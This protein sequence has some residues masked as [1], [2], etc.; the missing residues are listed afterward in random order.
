MDQNKLG[1]TNKLLTRL[2]RGYIKKYSIRISIAL[3]AMIIVAATTSMQAYIIKPILDSIFI[4]QNMD[5]ILPVSLALLGIAVLR[6]G[7][8][9]LQTT[10][11][12]FVGQRVVTDIQLSLYQH[13]IYSDLSALRRHSAG[14]LISRF[15]NDITIMRESISTIMTG[16]AREFLTT[17]GLICV[18]IYHDPMLSIVTLTIF[19]ITILPIVKLGRK[20]R[21]IAM[22]TQ[23]KLGEYTTTLDATF[24]N[25]KIVKSFAREPYEIQRAGKVVENIFANYVKAARTES[26]SAPMME[27]LGDLP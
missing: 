1:T 8:N 24:T 5:F 18:M 13:L 6:G 20:M 15:T 12:K 14:H 17:I 9:Y 26:L 4:S 10:S 19:P 2:F 23:E 25:I 16:V 21:R 27:I 22:N 3:L 11:M 7:A